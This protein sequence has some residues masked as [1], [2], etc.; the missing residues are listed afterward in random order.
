MSADQALLVAH[1]A[2]RVEHGDAGVV[3]GQ[4]ERVEEEQRVGDVGVVVG[5]GE[6]PERVGA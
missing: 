1:T 2:G 4:A 3:W 5:G 6:Q